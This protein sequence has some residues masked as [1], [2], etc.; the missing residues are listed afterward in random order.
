[1]S[2]TIILLPRAPAHAAEF[3]VS[4]AGERIAGFAQ[5][6]AVSDLVPG[7]VVASISRR[8]ADARRQEVR[9]GRS[10]ESQGI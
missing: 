6:L 5:V 3:F 4:S 8:W 2:P 9:D 7:I 1:M 10:V